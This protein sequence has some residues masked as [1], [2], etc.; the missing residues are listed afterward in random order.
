MTIKILNKLV[1]LGVLYLY[2]TGSSR[3][4]MYCRNSAW[5]TCVYERGLLDLCGHAT[6]DGR[7]RIEIENTEQSYELLSIE[8]IMKL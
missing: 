6:I 2:P 7:G 3:R 1:S 8:R 4:I 5:I